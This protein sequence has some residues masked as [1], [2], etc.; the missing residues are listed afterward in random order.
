MQALKLA[1]LQS[2]VNT[3]LHFNFTMY[4]TYAKDREQLIVVSSL[5]GS[6]LIALSSLRGH[7]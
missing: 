1:W 4:I 2:R 6:S 3:D 7:S 5:C